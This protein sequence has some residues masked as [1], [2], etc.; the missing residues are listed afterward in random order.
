MPETI[1]NLQAPGHF[2]KSDPVTRAQ[3]SLFPTEYLVLG[4]VGASGVS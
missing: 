3:S 1:Q 2:N 4:I